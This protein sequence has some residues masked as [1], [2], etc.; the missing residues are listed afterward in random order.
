MWLEVQ[1]N[2]FVYSLLHTHTL[3][4]QIDAADILRQ[5]DRQREAI[6]LLL[7]LALAGL[8]IGTK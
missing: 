5:Q 2:A 7:R 8:V 1:V 4:V 3:L 6:I